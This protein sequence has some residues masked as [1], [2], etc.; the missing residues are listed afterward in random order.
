MRNIGVR[1]CASEKDGGPIDR[2]LQD[3]YLWRRDDLLE[4]YAPNP[5]ELEGLIE[6]PLANVLR[7]YAGHQTSLNA[8]LLSAGNR[9]VEQV[10]LGNDL[11]VP[12]I[13]CYPYRVAIAIHAAIRGDEHIAI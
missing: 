4:T 9:Q 11:F 2:E 3:V 8:R 7:L 13:D 12:R 6:A 10:T 1:V 5:D